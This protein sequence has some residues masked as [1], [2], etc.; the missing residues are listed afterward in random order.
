MQKCKNCG[1]MNPNQAKFCEKCGSL[2]SKNNI[3]VKDS[4]KTKYIPWIVGVLLVFVFIGGSGYFIF[5]HFKP[6]HQRE[7]RNE[8]TTKNKNKSVLFDNK[9]SDS[10][11]TKKSG[12]T[13]DSSIA[14]ILSNDLSG[15][16]GETSAYYFGINDNKK[17]SYGNYDAEQRAASDI[18]LFIMAAAYREV[19]QGNISLSDRY[20]LTDADKVS[21][22]G[23]VQSMQSGDSLTYEDLINY[24][25]TKS[26]NTAANI[27]TK[28]IGGISVVNEEI[29][30]LNLNDTRMER[31]LM[32]QDALDSGKDNMSS[33]YDLALFL[34]KLYE[35][36]VVS[37]KYDNEMLSILSNDSNHS[38]L[39][40]QVNT[41]TVIIYNKTG[42]FGTYGVE[43]DAAIFKH[44]NKAF[45]LVVMSQDGSSSEQKSAMSSLGKDVTQKVLGD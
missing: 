4:K 26:D 39:P 31:M 16:N 5:N 7:T 30:R 14:S 20:T 25:I 23:V 27:I 33:A 19:S 24:M 40:N 42:E 38:K 1:H 28:Q 10:K 18:K 41:D 11:K 45:V 3:V 36:K 35:H 17:A 9:G 21:G 34:K 8:Q 6:V 22:T 32:D 44:D 43:N 15:I 13:T 29:N 2:L 12:I 37:T